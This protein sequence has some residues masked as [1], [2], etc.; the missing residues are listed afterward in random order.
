VRK[1]PGGGPFEAVVFSGGGCRCFWQA[2]L[3]STAA[4][5][6]GLEPRVVGAVSAGAAFACA[7]FAGVVDRVVEDFT[8]RVG[9]NPRNLYPANL[10]RGAPVFPHERI[11]RGTILSTLDSTAL[12]RLHAAP[13][14]RISLGRPPDWSGDRGGYL[15]GLVAFL[16]EQRKSGRV[17]AAWGRRFGFRSELVSV[18]DCVTPEQLADLILQSSCT[19]PLTPLYQ[20]SGRVVL[21]GGIV[22]HVPV[23]AVASARTSLVLLTRRYPEA[24]LPRV[25]G[26]IYLQP[27]EPIPVERWDYTSPD[28]VGRTYDLG[29]RDGE[30]FARRHL[31]RDAA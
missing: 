3:W 25:D 2:G 8:R 1:E 20:R 15:L 27:S 24:W 7:I 30:A 26:R 4:P 5:A 13:E 10:L 19:P 16:A 18:R 14:I 6:L 29:R 11:Y 22:D 23:D 31:R 28:L 17:H 9:A 21:D 12:A